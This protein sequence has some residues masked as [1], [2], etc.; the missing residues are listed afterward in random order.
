MT[1]VAPSQEGSTRSVDRALRLLAAVLESTTQGTLS[2][3][4]R[5]TELSA[6]TASRLLATLAQHDLVVRGEDGKYRSGTRMRQLAAAALRD[7]ALYE[8]VG[9][10]LI[11]LV[12]E[13][14]E[15][16]S[17]GVPGPPGEVLYLRQVPSPRQVQT[18]VWTGRTIPRDGTA[19]GAALDGATTPRGF[20]TSQRPDSDV[21]AVAAPVLGHNGE[22][23]G[24]IS[25]NAPAYRT[26]D[27]DVERYGAALVRHARELSVALGAPQ[28]LV[29]PA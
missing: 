22:I 24:A 12:E 20:V 7:N 13:T 3:L 26:T 8:L 10:H 15:T 27:A 1:S 17:L 21:T 9:P 14:S 19:L 28:H 23:L 29:G 5:A 4:A 6:A 25:I 2:D 11:Q 18:A 16:A